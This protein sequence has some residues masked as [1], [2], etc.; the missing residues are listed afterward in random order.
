MKYYL[1]DACQ[2]TFVFF[3]RLETSALD[4][5]FLKQ[6]HSTLLKE[7]RDDA[8]ILFNGRFQEEGF[9]AQMMVLGLDGAIA[10][11]CGNGA[12]VC[13]AYLFERYPRS[14]RHYLT[15]GSGIYPLQKYGSDLY[16][17]K[18]P[19]ANFAW[20]EKFIADFA[21][22]EGLTRFF[23]VNMLEPHLILQ[24]ELSDEQLL[25]L[26]KELNQRKDLFPS[27][28][29][30]N[31]WHLLE[32]DRLFV[33]TYERGVQRLTLSCGTGS[34]SCA[35]FHKSLGTLFVSTPGGDL[36]VILQEDGIELKGPAF[37]FYKNKKEEGG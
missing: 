12:R 28:I 27:G 18:L 1:G 3:D 17:V 36:E 20:N 33:K 5:S 37:F 31:A 34:M 23:Y 10:E 2:N 35:A 22:F 24:E 8:L 19:P 25:S 21:A 16:S 9:Y 6:V 13:A 15:T 4:E 7:K 14:K 32:D 26:G 11:F 29:N 30:V